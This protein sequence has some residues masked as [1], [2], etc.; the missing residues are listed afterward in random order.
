VPTAAGAAIAL[1][2]PI[3]VLVADALDKRVRRRRTPFNGTISPVSKT[4]N[5]RVS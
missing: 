4:P 5:A 1:L 3:A 2:T